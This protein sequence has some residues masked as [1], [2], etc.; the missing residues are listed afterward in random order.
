MHQH[1]G[2]DP[3]R[4]KETPKPTW[5]A[6]TCRLSGEQLWAAAGRPKRNRK[7]KSLLQAEAKPGRQGSW[8]D[9]K[10]PSYCWVCS[11]YDEIR[12]NLGQDHD[13]DNFWS[14]GNAAVVAV[15]GCK[16][17][18]RQFVSGDVDDGVRFLG[19][20]EVVGSRFYAWS[21]WLQLRI[22]GQLRDSK[23]LHGGRVC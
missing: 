22:G 6:V 3:V 10:H 11:K 9:Q 21:F 2:W 18:M 17:C 19:V 14:S 4:H 13:R 1:T 5:A 8:M 7:K 20:D 23:P 16:P 15:H 12:M